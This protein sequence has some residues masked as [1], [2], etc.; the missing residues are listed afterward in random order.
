MPSGIPSELPLESLVIGTARFTPVKLGGFPLMIPA[1][2]L[3]E[4]SAAAPPE[5]IAGVLP[6]IFYKDIFDRFSKKFFLLLETFLQ[7]FIKALLLKFLQDY[8]STLFLQGY[9]QIFLQDFLKTFFQA[10]C[11]GISSGILS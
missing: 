4:M 5:I 2:I 3:L 1:G 7:E 9:L 8:F 6:E 10:L 11:L